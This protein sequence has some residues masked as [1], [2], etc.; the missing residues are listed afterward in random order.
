MKKLKPEIVEKLIEGLRTNARFSEELNSL[1]RDE[2]KAL[3]AMAAQELFR[4]SKE[5]ESLLTRI[6]YVDDILKGVIEEAVAAEDDKPP[7][8]TLAAILPLLADSECRIVEQYRQNLRE[9]RLEIQTQTLINRRATMDTL[10]CLNEAVSLLTGPEASAP[11]T[12]GAA[13][14]RRSSV[15]PSLISREV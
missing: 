12:Y 9:L 5:K 7:V 3:K 10:S 13:G 8:S 2:N 14:F 1:L 11:A 4:L 15:Q 6:Q